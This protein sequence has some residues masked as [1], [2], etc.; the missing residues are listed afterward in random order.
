MMQCNVR[1]IGVRIRPVIHSTHDL[2]LLLVLIRS[3][4]VQMV[5]LVPND[6]PER[7]ISQEGLKTARALPL[8]VAF[9]STVEGGEFLITE[10]VHIRNRI[11]EGS[12]KFHNIAPVLRKSNS[13]NRITRIENFIDACGMGGGGDE[14]IERRRNRSDG[15]TLTDDD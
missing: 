11:E 15:E 9:I 12:A 5:V 2:S 7:V 4:L 14:W 6:I 8:E 3:H 13:I 1:G 10:H